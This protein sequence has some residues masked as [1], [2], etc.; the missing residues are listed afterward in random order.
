LVVDVAVAVSTCVALLALF[1]S[2]AAAFAVAV[3]VVGC[4]AVCELSCGVS[5]V[6][7]AAVVTSLGGNV[8]KVAVLAFGAI[9]LDAVITVF[10][11]AIFAFNLDAFSRHFF[12]WL[13]LPCP[14]PGM[15]GVRTE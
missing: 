12:L 15:L 1:V 14:G 10:T 2:T 5:S 6:G 7:S 3:A 9:V 13:C 11:A 4:I 8:V